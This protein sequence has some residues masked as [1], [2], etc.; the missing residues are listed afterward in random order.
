MDKSTLLSYMPKYYTTSKVIDSIN[1]S[2]AIELTNFSNNLDSILNQFFIDTATFGL[3]RWEKEFGI[4]V[5]N[6]LD[7]EYRRSRIKAKLR[8]SG[9]ITVKLIENV[10]KSFENADLQVIENNANYSFTIKFVSTI[11][12]PPNINDLKAIIEQIKPAHL[13]VLYEFKYRIWNEFLSKSWD[14]V[15]PNSWDNLKST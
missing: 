15:K 1:N 4:E 5:N 14:T 3:D 8:G 12:I 6:N 13:Q 7:T 10:A 2:N 11:G 9:T